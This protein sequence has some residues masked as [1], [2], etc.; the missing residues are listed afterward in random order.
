MKKLF[1]LLAMAIMLPLSINAQGLISAYIVDGD[2]PVTNIRNAPNGKIVA[3]LPTDAN[4]IVTLNYAK[5]GWWN[6]DDEVFYVGDEEKTEKLKGSKTGYWV[7]S[8]LLGFG[9]TG[10]PKGALRTTPSSKAKAL[11]VYFYP[12]EETLRPI[13]I[14]GDWVKVTFVVNGKKH[15]GWL[16]RDRICDNPLTTCP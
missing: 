15:T 12:G 4:I 16:H 10:D 8:S 7:H 14:K 3:T 11:K 5:D 6:I 9:I 13:D 1:L 2:G